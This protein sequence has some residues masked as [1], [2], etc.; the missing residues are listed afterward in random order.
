MHNAENSASGVAIGR[1]VY[2]MEGLSTKHLFRSL[3]LAGSG[4]NAQTLEQCDIELR[5]DAS[6][7]VAAGRWDAALPLQHPEM[8][9]ADV[10]VSSGF[11]DVHH[12][13]HVETA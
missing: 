5:I 3:Q 1:C 4:A 8:L 12:A 13:V 7:E 9:R 11:A 6:V 10:E 2:E